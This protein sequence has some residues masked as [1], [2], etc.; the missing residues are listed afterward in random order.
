MPTDVPR[1]LVQRFVTIALMGFSDSGTSSISLDMGERVALTRPSAN[2]LA[3][4]AS[5][6]VCMLREDILKGVQVVLIT[7]NPECLEILR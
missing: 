5:I 2:G 7:G 1:S 4:I 3:R 6:F